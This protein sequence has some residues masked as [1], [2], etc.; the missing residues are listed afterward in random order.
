M[1]EIPELFWQ[2][3]LEENGFV[4]HYVKIKN[5]VERIKNKE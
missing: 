2:V 1:L 3:I 4:K 5:L